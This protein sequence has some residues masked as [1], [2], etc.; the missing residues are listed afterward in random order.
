[1][2]LILMGPI[3][4]GK[5]NMCHT[6]NYSKIKNFSARL[7]FQ[8]KIA[9]NVVWSIRYSYLI[10]DRNLQYKW[11]DIYSAMKLYLYGDR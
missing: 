2:P 3:V 4:K 9:L 11:F 6:V 5:K 10:N 1:M 8:I 7:I